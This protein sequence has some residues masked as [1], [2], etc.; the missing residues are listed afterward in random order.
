MKTH[1]STVYQFMLESTNHTTAR[2][3][4]RRKKEKKRK[5]SPFIFARKRRKT[6]RRKNVFEIFLAKA[7][8]IKKG[9]FPF[10]FESNSPN[11]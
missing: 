1:C 8:F 2:K 7:L 4:T 10:G 3:P 9:I 11:T 6:A 5:S